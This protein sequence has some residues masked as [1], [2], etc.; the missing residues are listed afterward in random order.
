[1]LALAPPVCHL[2]LGSAAG[3]KLV[4]QC[5]TFFWTQDAP[6]PLNILALRAVA[7][8]NDGDTAIRYVDSLVEDS[9]GDE[10]AICASPEAIQD[11]SAL[12]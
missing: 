2:F 12:F 8:D 9:P 10:L 3:D 1:M 7:A 11:V 6:Q 4:E 5:L